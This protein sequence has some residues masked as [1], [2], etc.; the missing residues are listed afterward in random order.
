[1]PPRFTARDSRTG[2][3]TS[4]IARLQEGDLCNECMQALFGIESRTTLHERL[5]DAED[6]MPSGR[7]LQHPSSSLC[8][9]CGKVQRTVYTLATRLT[10]RGSQTAPGKGITTLRQ[11]LGAF[12]TILENRSGHDDPSSEVTVFSPLFVGTEWGL[13]E[14]VHRA[15]HDRKVIHAVYGGHPVTLAPLHLWWAQGSWYLMAHRLEPLPS[16]RGWRKES[17]GMRSGLKLARLSDLK[18]DP[19]IPFPAGLPKARQWLGSGDWLF[20][21]DAR[22]NQIAV[23]ALGGRLL[24]YFRERLESGIDDDMK[25]WSFDSP[26]P[27]WLRRHLPPSM[28]SRLASDPAKTLCAYGEVGNPEDDAQTGHFLRDDTL[29]AIVAFP[30]PYGAMGSEERRV[31]EFEAA[32]RI[33]SWGG[34]AVV[35]ASTSLAVRVH[36]LARIACERQRM[37]LE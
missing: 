30:Y 15:V 7:L 36:E 5:K 27:D 16:G 22:E 12:L 4:M 6:L 18:E 24:H 25:L 1:M 34:E 8:P 21:G 29:A 35:L 31:G 32:R 11:D 26:F 33:L 19:S 3:A 17:R 20:R 9:S 28:C 2:Q 14:A 10:P 13:W 23:V 37:F